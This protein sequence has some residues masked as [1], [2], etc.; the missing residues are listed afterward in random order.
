MFDVAGGRR[1]NA[2]IVAA[3]SDLIVAEKV[4]ACWT[5]RTDGTIHTADDDQ[6]N[7]WR[8][9]ALAERDR[10]GCRDFTASGV[11]P[12]FS[13]RDLHSDSESDNGFVDGADDTKRIVTANG[14]FAYSGDWNRIERSSRPTHRAASLLHCVR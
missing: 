11:L 8:P 5:H 10:D 13:V 3:A 9:P 4:L 2:P 1:F 6:A 12:S 14:T 7:D